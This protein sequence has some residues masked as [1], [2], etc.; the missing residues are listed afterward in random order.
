MK[1]QKGWLP[2]ISKTIW[3]VL[4]DD[5]LPVEAIGEYLHYLD[6]LERSPNTIVSYARNLKMY[7][8]FLQDNHYDWKEIKTRELADF[9]HWLRNPNPKVISLKPQ[10]SIRCEKTINHAITTVIG[11]YEFHSN[12]G[13]VRT[14]NAYKNTSFTNRK[15]KSLLYH[16][17]QDKPIRSKLLKL[18]EP[19]TFPRCLTKNE[20]TQLINGCN[21][22][23]DKF[24][25]CLLYETGM[26]IGE[27]LGLRHE[28]IDSTGINEINVVKRLNNHNGARAKSGRRTIHVSKELMQ[29]YGDYL[30]EEYPEEIESDYV[31]VNCYKKPIGIPIKKSNIDGLFRRLAKKTGIKASPHLFRHTHATELIRAGWDMM[32]IQKR[33]GHAS[34]QTTINTYVHLND[35]D[36][37]EE[38]KKYL[39][40]KK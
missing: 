7:W 40:R 33:L 11:F 15:Y 19:K 39:K 23:R 12:M 34:V 17:N 14:L 32:H 37:K 13:T 3:M 27:V 21:C 6:N 5:F 8:E 18:K 31:F 29:L 24:L 9:I 22:K 1:L 26:R 35:S 28:D 38:Y 36:L 25:I 10:Q 16:I 20:V 4:D 2:N 30:I